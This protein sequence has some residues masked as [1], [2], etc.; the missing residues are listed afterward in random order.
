MEDENYFLGRVIVHMITENLEVVIQ[1]AAVLSRSQERHFTKMKISAGPGHASD[2][3]CYQNASW[4][5]SH[6]Y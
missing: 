3:R 5:L 4:K 2:H 6:S 1:V